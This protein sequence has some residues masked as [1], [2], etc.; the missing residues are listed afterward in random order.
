[1]HFRS[2]ETLL[3]SGATGN[4]G[5][6][7]VALALAMGARCVLAPGRNAAVLHDLR[8]RFGPRVVPVRLSGDGA[9]DTELMK[10]AAPGPIDAVQDFLLPPSAPAW[11]APRS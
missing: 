11:R 4:F 5:S 2:G 1:M 7:T 6:A 3:V 8:A 10:R 9:A